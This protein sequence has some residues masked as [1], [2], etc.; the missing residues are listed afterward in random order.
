MYIYMPN[1][2]D[3]YI[4]LLFLFL[5]SDWKKQSYYIGFRGCWVHLP[6]SDNSFQVW[7]IPLDEHSW[8][9]LICSLLPWRI[10]SF[11]WIWMGMCSLVVSLCSSFWSGP[12]CRKHVICLAPWDFEGRICPTGK[13]A[14]AQWGLQLGRGCCIILGFRI[15]KPTC[16]QIKP[17]SPAL[18][19]T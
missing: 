18:T 8:F 1:G 16:P 5:L 17:H 2:I 4:C 6:R 13:S 10:N 12:T 9:L 7:G 15:R 3:M 14:L 19:V 11:W